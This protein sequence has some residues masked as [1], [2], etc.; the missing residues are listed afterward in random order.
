MPPT[1]DQVE[2]MQQLLAQEVESAAKLRMLLKQEQQV[3]AEDPAKI[4]SVARS[5]YELLRQLEA[6]HEQR[7]R[8]LADAGFTSDRAGVE[9]YLNACANRSLKTA[10]E[11]LLSV[12]AECRENNQVN[13][14]IV[15]H[16]R[17][18][19][20]DTLALLHGANPAAATYDPTG[21]TS[22]TGISRSWAKA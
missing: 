19:I 13:A 16:S 12:V 9:R 21:R 2:R 1:S 11:Q 8:V 6:L 4:E 10:W 14:T 3:L 15:A 20:R 5:K 7:R 17:R 18:A 22:D